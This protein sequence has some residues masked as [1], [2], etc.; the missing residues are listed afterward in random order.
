MKI[1][2]PEMLYQQIE[3]A[4]AEAQR[5]SW[6]GIQPVDLMVRL[7]GLT[8]KQV[9]VEMDALCKMGRLVKVGHGESRGYRLATRSQREAFAAKFGMVP[10]GEITFS[11]HTDMVYDEIE[12]VV[13]K[14]YRDL[15]RGVF[16]RDIQPRLPYD[17]RAEG[18]LRR[19]MLAMYQAGRLV[20][21]GGHG[22]RQGYRLPTRMERLCFSLNRGMWPHGTE[23][24]VSWA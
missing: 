4:M 10:R 2:N 19:D 8:D 21:V 1:N 5:T 3:A 15:R 17:D 24:V 6:R 23:F 16:P 18:S 14:A 9:Q 20:R 7:P 11:E 13:A 22:A 12:K